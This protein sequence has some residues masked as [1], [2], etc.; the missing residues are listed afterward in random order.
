MKK[1][2]ILLLIT[3]FTGLSGLLL[4]SPTSKEDA[5][6]KARQFYSEN[7]Q[8]GLR[9]GMDF[10]LVYSD[11][12]RVVNNSSGSEFVCFYVFNAGDKDGFV[13]VSG[14]D[15]V[16][17]ILAYSDEGSFPTGKIPENICNWLNYYS[18]EIQ[19]VVANPSSQ[20]S[21]NTTNETVPGLRTTNSAATPLLGRIRWDQGDPYNL[22]CPY[23]TK[24]SQK[25]VTGCVATAMAQVMKYYE[26][27][28]QGTGSSGYTFD[29]DSVST[30]LTANFGQTT[31]K[32][33]EMLDNYNATSTL[34]QDSAVALLVYHCGVAVEMDYNTSGGGGSSASL[35]DA[36]ISLKNN[37]GYDSD[38]QLF[39]REFFNLTS[40]TEKLMNEIDAGRPVLYAGGSDHGGH[41]F[42]CD[43]YDSDSL[44][45][46]NWGWGGSANGYF[47]IS[48][49]DPEY[50]GIGSSSGG[51]S[52]D[53]YAIAGIQK[54]DGVN[55]PS[56][57]LGMYNFGMTSN[58]SSLS[59][60]SSDKFNASLGFLNWG[61]NSFS[62]YVAAGLFK[63]GI[64]QKYLSRVS[65]SNI[66][67][68]S[69]YNYTF[70]NLSLSG[71]AA[72]N[73]Q[74]YLVHQ[75]SGGSTWFQVCGSFSLNNYLDITIS[76]SSATITA[77][78]IKP[79]LVLTSEIQT[80]GIIYQNK[81]GR[82]DISVKN[83]GVEFYSYLS[84]YIY[85][86]TNPSV[87]QY[88]DK[89]LTVIRNGETLSVQLIGSISLSPGTYNAIAVYD[90]TNNFS[91]DKF[92][93][94]DQS[95]FTPLQFTIYSEPDNPVM[96]LLKK[97]SITGGN[98]LYIDKTLSLNA[99][100]KNTGGFY[101]NQIL[102]FI[103]P[104][105]GVSSLGYLNPLTIF[106]D[107]DETKTYTLTGSFDL[108]P[109]N[110]V[111]VLYYY[112]D[113]WKSFT[114]SNYYYISVTLHENPVSIENTT[115]ESMHLSSNPVEESIEIITSEKVLQ[116]E[117]YDLN[118]RMLG[119]F[120]N[121]VT[122][123]AG[124]LNKGLYILRVTTD[125]GITNVCF[126]K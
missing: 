5:L 123:P 55:S 33:N 12:G 94:V 42:V 9:S 40:W 47:S 49:L 98:T 21:P 65:F 113:G 48:I 51:Y 89:G 83:N 84:I 50:S 111:I 44:F 96:T 31:Y 105:T 117:I 35:S 103:F 87:N 68:Y 72:G 54:P 100:I 125:R 92:Q 7:V 59:N 28:I 41:A 86:A 106:I 29:L 99:E 71:L 6:K 58:K 39:R 102:A 104:S 101:D 61:L 108:D 126:I 38:L 52:Q 66:N 112:L 4:A 88:L 36:G 70:N 22:L 81:T 124:N 109:G 73:Y 20:T 13:I 27:P 120:N 46:F 122:L 77:P 110:Y 60:I 90:S 78:S 43:G 82:F 26:W 64:F 24:Y 107:T 114:T 67:T 118:G 17:P 45:H 37:F 75:P 11:T 63:N 79:E 34:A 25:T 95:S 57:Q 97:I 85:S 116:A 19:Y 76:G 2:R 18:K 74:L 62:G 1:F 10:Q 30:T 53:Q 69:G 14:D 119:K 23:S 15:A 32:W 3:L 93:E 121:S 91:T 16:K 80:N 115:T 56:Y 8:N